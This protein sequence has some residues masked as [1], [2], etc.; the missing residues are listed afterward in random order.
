MGTGL[1]ALRSAGARIAALTVAVVLSAGAAPGPA[2]A[3]AATDPT[4]P[5]TVTVVG[6]GSA[7]AEPDLVRLELR[8]Q[9]RAKDL[10][11]AVEKA[12]AGT[13]RVRAALVARGVAGRDILTPDLRPNRDSYAPVTRPRY[14]AFQSMSIA[15]RDRRTADSLMGAAL[16]AGGPGVAIDEV[17][18]EITGRET[19]LRKARAAAFA[20]AKAKAERYAKEAGRPLGAVRS[21]HEAVPIGEGFAHFAC[22]VMAVSLGRPLGVPALP[23]GP[24]PQSLH[25]TTTVAWTLG[26]ADGTAPAERPGTLSIGGLGIALGAPGLVHGVL[27][28]YQE[29]GK[30]STARSRADATVRRLRAALAGY[31]VTRRDID[32]LRFPVVR[33]A[34]RQSSAKVYRAEYRLQVD[35]R[36]PDRAAR[37]WAAAIDAGGHAADP[38]LFDYKVAR[39]KALREAARVEALAYARAKAQQYAGLTGRRLGPLR[40]V[41]DAA[42]QQ[43]PGT[44]WG[45]AG[46]PVV[47]LPGGRNVS[48][49]AGTQQVMFRT[50]VVWD[51]G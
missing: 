14:L 38:W 46:F 10:S 17:T 5:G 29:A 45:A 18:Y 42:H 48:P 19:V 6:D 15:L 7:A 37:A 30:A 36:D 23:P 34:S 28:V 50:T 8:I 25:V 20:D 33:T 27:E 31:G 1:I 32:L 12:A 39:A 2:R 11:T 21:V 13:R 49:S 47:P 41:T 43:T 26:S 3:A 35:L 24:G 4:N 16:A 40:S 51:L 9:A 44:Y 22:C